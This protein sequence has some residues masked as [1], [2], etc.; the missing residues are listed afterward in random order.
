M[1]T[2]Q[3]IIRFKKE[4]EGRIIEAVIWHLAAAL[5]GSSLPYKY[6]LYYG[7]ADGTCIVRYDNEQGKDDHRHL[8]TREEPYLF[9]TL[10]KLI[11]DF[12]ADIERIWTLELDPSRATEAVVAG[13]VL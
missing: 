13:A 7:D 2:A 11:E 3:E 1:G 4:R 5:P 10:C 6:R 12:E 9:S 8:A